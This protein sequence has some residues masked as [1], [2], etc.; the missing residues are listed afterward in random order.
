M[1]GGAVAEDT[2]DLSL[3]CDA[4]AF[5]PV[6]EYDVR[7]LDWDHDYELAATAFPTKGLSRADWLAV[8]EI[9]FTYCAVVEGERALSRAAVWRGVPYGDH[10]WEVAAVWTC[11]DRRGRGLARSTVSFVTECVIANDRVATL[12]TPPTNAAMLRAARS[13]GFEVVTSG[14]IERR[15]SGHQ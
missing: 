11:E 15:L 1:S 10:G 5:Q 8:R 3:W 7:W 6:R 12:H 13:V 2:E 4:H 14:E 9:G